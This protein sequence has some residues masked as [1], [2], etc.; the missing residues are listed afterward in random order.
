MANAT[1]SNQATSQTTTDT[2]SNSTSYHLNPAMRHDFVFF[3]DVTDGNPN[4]DPD[5]ANSPRIDI[6]TSQ[7]LVTDGAIKRKI[8]NFIEAQGGQNG[9][10]RNK[11]YVQGDEALVT[12]HKRAYEA[13]GLTS[14]GTKQRRDD[15][16]AAR[17]WMCANF[18]DVR[19][20]GAVMAVGVNVGRVHGPLQI[21][22]ARSVDPI[23]PAEIT[24]T[25]AAITREEDM[26]VVIDDEGKATGGK[27]TEMGRKSIIPYG[28][29]KA[30]GFFTPAHA[31][32]TGVTSEDLTLL[33]TALLQMWEVDRS[34]ARGFMATRGLY[35]F[36]HELPLGS[37]PAHKLFDRI[38][39]AHKP[40]VQAPRS[41]SDYTIS[42]GDD[43]L[44]AGVYLT[45]LA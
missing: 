2:T 26:D 20:F 12:K 28:L 38:Q 29:Y 5:A 15:V 30:Y 34:S 23:A 8:R 33:W 25:R 22:F 40:E 21:T 13:L 10:M 19:M 41:F 24:I 4:G 27:E 11:I 9:D 6:E 35:I 44:P 3:F 45:N 16:A 43:P 1:L 7:G 18:Y 14:T 31:A 36:S 17:A 39:V 37:A 42:T 32:A